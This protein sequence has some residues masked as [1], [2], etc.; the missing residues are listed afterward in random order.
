MDRINSDSAKIE[1][2]IMETNQ[3][4]LKM[5]QKQETTNENI[6][7]VCGVMVQKDQVQS[8][9]DYIVQRSIDNFIKMRE[10]EEMEMQKTDDQIFDDLIN[11]ED[12]SWY[13]EPYN[14]LYAIE[15][16]YIEE[17]KEEG[18]IET[19]EEFD[20]R[21]NHESS[22]TE[23]QNFMSGR[24]NYAPNG[25]H[26]VNNT[27]DFQDI[28]AIIGFCKD[29]EYEADNIQD[30]MNFVISTIANEIWE[31]IEPHKEAIMERK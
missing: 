5:S 10:L 12:F 29:R 15:Q 17:L 9:T 6:V 13:D 18:N 1:I 28:N 8:F 27:L 19:R 30:M 23:Y 3:E 4:Q 21:F 14:I 2:E 22:W 31:M 11:R 20:Y 26:I 25:Q 24:P 7:N 16:Y